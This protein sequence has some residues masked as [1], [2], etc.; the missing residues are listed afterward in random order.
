MARSNTASRA[1]NLVPSGFRR[2]WRDRKEDVLLYA[3]GLAFYALVS[4]IPLAIVSLWVASVIAGDS[5]VET[6]AR[7]LSGA[8][9]EGLGIDR[10]VARVAELGTSLG[11]TAV[12]AAL[13]PAT[14]Y[15]AGLRRAFVRLGRAEEKGEGFRGRGLVLLVLLPLFVL[16]TLLGAFAMTTIFRDGVSAIL[17]WVLALVLAFVGATLALFAI[18]HIFPVKPLSGKPL[19]LAM[20]LAGAGI[21]VASFLF[22]IALGFGANFK[23]HYAISGIAAIVLLG[24]WLFVSNGLVLVAYVA[25]RRG[26]T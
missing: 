8:L 5:R 12:I 1:S 7:T 18:Y 6:L 25:A 17:G 15:G 19:W 11:I 3:A 21:A 24:L 4:V 10:A 9:P 14:A 13:W 23:E 16:G 22:A 20:G 2:A 26:R